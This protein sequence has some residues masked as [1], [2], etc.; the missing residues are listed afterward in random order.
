MTLLVILTAVATFAVGYMT[1]RVAK[2]GEFHEE[3][4]SDYIRR[5]RELA[6]APAFRVTGGETP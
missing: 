6:M 4:T 5:M 1:G 3:N 2:V